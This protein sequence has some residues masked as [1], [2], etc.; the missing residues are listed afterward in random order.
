MMRERE[1]ERERERRTSSS[2]RDLMMMTNNYGWLDLCHINH[3]RL[4]DAKSLRIYEGHTI[5]FQT[6]FAWA[7]KIVVDAWKLTMLL[8]YILWDDRPIF[9]ISGTNEQLQQQVKYN[10]LNPDCHS[11]WMSKMQSDTLEERYAIKFCFKLA[12][13][14]TTKTY[15]MLQTAFGA[16]CMNRASVFE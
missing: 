2:Q 5:S 13:K 10:L 15:G 1:R 11:W 7:F 14:D 9:R 3:C 12:K 4:F 16:S 6:F 8:L